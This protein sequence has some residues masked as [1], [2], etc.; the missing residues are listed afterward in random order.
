MT[1]DYLT[2]SSNTAIGGIGNPNGVGVGGGINATNG[3]LLLLDSIVAENPSGSDFYASFG[4]IT[5]GGDNISSDISFP[6]SAPGSLNNTNPELGTLGNYGGPTQTVPLLAGSP[7]IDAGGAGGCPATD[8]RGVPR[9]IGSACDVGAFEYSNTSYSIQGQVQSYGSTGIIT[10]SAGIWSSVVD[11]QGNYVI[12]NILAGTYAVTPSS[13]IPGII[14]APSNTTITVGPNAMN[15]NFTARPGNS[16][17]TWTNPAPITYATALS[18]NQLDAT[19]NVP[20]SFA[21]TPTNGAILNTGTNTLSVIFTSTDTVDYAGVTDTVSLVVLKVPLTVT[22]ANASRAYG[23]A[24]P[25]FTGTIFGLTNGD[26]ITAAYSTTAT[27]NSPVGEYL[28]VPSLVAPNDRQTNYTIT[29]VDGALT[30]G[31]LPI[32]LTPPLSQTVGVGV[33]TNITFSV[34]VSGPGPVGYQWQFNGADL[35]SPNSSGSVTTVTGSGGTTGGEGVPATNA[36]LFY[37]ADVTMDDLGDLFIADQQDNLVRKVDTNGIITI[38]AGNGTFGGPSRLQELGDG[39]PAIDASLSPSGVALNGSGELFIADFDDL[40]VRKVGTNGIITTVAGGG[41]ETGNGVPAIDAGLYPARVAVDAMGNLIIADLYRN[42]VRKVDANGIITTVAGGGSA[43][44]SFGDGGAATNAVLVDPLGLAFDASG[45]LFIADEGHNTIRKVDTNGIISTVAGNGVAAFA[46]DG[47]MATNASLN[48]PNGVAVD[49]AGN[50]FISDTDNNRI[51]KVDTNGIITTVAGTGVG[52]YGSDGGPALDA[53][54]DNPKGIVLDG[55]GDLFIADYLNSRIRKFAFQGPS[56]LISNVSMS[57]VGSYDVVV[58]NIYGSVTSSVATLSIGSTPVVTWSQPIPIVYGTAL[59]SNQLNAT[60]SLPGNFA[61]SPTNGAI[62]NTGTN[63][64]SVI[65]TPTD[66]VD[67]SSVTDTVNLIVLPALLTVTAASTNR[68]FGQANPVFTGT[69]F[70]VTNGDNITAAYSAAATV[71]SPVGT[72]PIVPSLVDPND[73]QTNYTVSLVS[74]A[75]TVGQATPVLTWSNPAPITYGTALSI[76]QLNAATTVSG[77]FAYTPTNGAILNAGTNTLSLIFTPTDT[78]DYSSVTDTVNLIVLPAPLTVTAASTN[79]MYGQ[80]NPVFTGT[81]IGLTNSDNITATYSTTATVNSPAGMY[82]IVPS[83]MDPNDRQTN[84]TVSL[85]D[86]TLT[87]GR[88]TSVLTWSN[89][90]PITYGTALTTN[91]LNATANVPGSFAYTPTN[92]SVLNAGTNLLSVIFTPSDAMDYTSASDTVS[93][94]VSPPAP[95]TLQFSTLDNL[96]ILA[97]PTNPPGVYLQ[98]ATDLS[99]P[100]NWVPVSG[101]IVIGVQ[102]EF[103]TN[104]AG[105][106]AF[107]RLK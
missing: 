23:Q 69:I 102:N 43:G 81:I 11:S 95:V 38:V 15:V 17:V 93:L 48:S 46:G 101:S 29:L 68:A 28:I 2:I 60:A 26:N 85:V 10:V 21:Y 67:Y 52:G 25:I 44:T 8:Q 22:A 62:L 47:G 7:A 70:G 78:V 57:N 55:L 6:F 75:L 16:V 76:N 83:L 72:Y 32:I 31:P 12:S 27:V 4:A 63:P 73:L 3:S 82:P 14:F 88:A 33:T 99:S 74:G 89:P 35:P 13:S 105:G 59:S 84:Y 77:T 100:L 66:T 71:N 61:Y 97:W 98:T 58:S 80:A 5:D 41:M 50:L 86:G 94:V 9:P 1:L 40:R 34:A 39:G 90:S 24:N 36:L 54:F 65:F 18:T 104:M 19:A 30:V 103:I 56:L 37:P 42:C 79:R 92:G 106:S 49:A 45:E 96:L 107:F 51:R 91:Q 64:L 87:V 20:G 53:S